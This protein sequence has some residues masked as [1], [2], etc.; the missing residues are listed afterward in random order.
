MLSKRNIPGAFIGKRTKVD[1]TDPFVATAKTAPAAVELQAQGT[2]TTTLDHLGGQR[3]VHRR[4]A[5][6]PLRPFL[7]LGP[8][9][10][11]PW[12]TVA[13]PAVRQDPTAPGSASGSS[14]LA[15]P[16][17]RR[18]AGCPSLLPS[19]PVQGE[20]GEGGVA[21]PGGTPSTA[22]LHAA[23]ARGLGLLWNCSR[24]MPAKN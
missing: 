14:S 10:A 12:P 5:A 22:Q 19:L 8:T 4:E 7:P 17:G 20:W 18:V 16:C 21:T 23:R 2:L 13:G 6:P 15:A 9:W 24:A 3:A 1:V 11:G